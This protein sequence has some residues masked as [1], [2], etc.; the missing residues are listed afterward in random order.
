MNVIF[1][2]RKP[3][4]G[5]MPPD[6]CKDALK[7]ISLNQLELMNLQRVI[8]LTSDDNPVRSALLE[9]KKDFES[10]EAALWEVLGFTVEKP[11][12]TPTEKT[13]AAV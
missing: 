1:N 9:W 3:F 11:D 10:R 6:K 2:P 8:D 5:N 12:H 7:L 4:D 13:E